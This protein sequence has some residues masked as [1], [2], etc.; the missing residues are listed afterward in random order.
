E[1]WSGR[2]GA[3]SGNRGDVGIAEDRHSADRQR[4]AAVVERGDADVAAAADVADAIY[5]GGQHRGSRRGAEQIGRG[6]VDEVAVLGGVAVLQI[7]A[8]VDRAREGAGVDD[9]LGREIAETIDGRAG[10]GVGLH[11]RRD[12]GDHLDV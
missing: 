12:R 1:G 5:A 10:L 4:R 9:N 8:E 11:G 6:H 7:E 2:D 3:W